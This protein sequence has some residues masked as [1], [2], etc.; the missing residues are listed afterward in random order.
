AS[1]FGFGKRSGLT[2]P[3]TASFG[4][5]QTARRPLVNE[6]LTP[7]GRLSAP[8]PAPAPAAAA[9]DAACVWD[10]H[11]VIAPQLLDFFPKATSRARARG[12]LA[13]QI[14]E[15]VMR[16]ARDQGLPLSDVQMRDTVTVLLNELIAAIGGLQ[17]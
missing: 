6:P 5:A 13:A 1:S 12:E 16:V 7:E 8:A 11:A 14:E 9:S 17:P 10:I 3:A 4:S 15:M 2:P